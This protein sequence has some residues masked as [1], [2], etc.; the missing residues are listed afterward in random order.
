M[1]TVFSYILSCFALAAV[2][3]SCSAERAHIHGNI[4]GLP[5]GMV[6]LR[7]WEGGMPAA[8]STR[9][10]GGRFSIPVPDVVPNMMYLQFEAFPD[11]YIPVFI[12]GGEVSVSGNT[13][14]Y[15]DIEVT[16][17]R[18]ND[19]FAAFRRSVRHYNVQMA[20]IDL[21]MRLWAD[22]TVVPDSLLRVSLTSK[23]DSLQAIVD[24]SR[25]TFMR[26]NPDCIVSAMFAVSALTDSTTSQQLSEILAPL[27]SMMHDNAFLRLLMERKRQLAK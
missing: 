15:D 23:R 14:Y 12:D 2:F 5:D 10:M 13:N 17:T 19:S 27:D 1:R 8:D 21:E 25:W 7:A 9:S 11:N 16:G 22:S 18:A 20:A 4:T 3:V 6:W 24:S 26:A